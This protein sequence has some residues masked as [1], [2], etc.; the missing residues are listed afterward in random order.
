MNN[1]KPVFF[2]SLIAM[3]SRLNLNPADVLLLF[4]QESGLNSRSLT[5]K[6]VGLNQ[7][8]GDY[9]KKYFSG[10]REQYAAL[11]PEKQLES[12]EAFFKDLIGGRNITSAAQLYCGNFLPVSLNFPGVISKDRSTVLALRSDKPGSDKTYVP[13]GTLTYAAAY[14]G[15]KGLDYDHDGSIT[16]GDIEDFLKAKT[17]DSNYQWALQELSK[18]SGS[19]HQSTLEEDSKIESTSE[20]EVEEEGEIDPEGAIIGFIDMIVD[21]MNNLM[22]SMNLTSFAALDEE[23]NFIIKLSSSKL[24]DNLEVA[25]IL[26]AAYEDLL[27]AKCKTYTNG[28]FVEISCKARG[29]HKKCFAAIDQFSNELL[30]EFKNETKIDNINLNIFANK[31]PSYKELDIKTAETNYRKFQLK[32]L[33][34]KNG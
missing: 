1:L 12:I 4:A 26:T 5:A 14:D 3:C 11:A 20:N 32:I 21:G 16:Y 30:N 31:E 2:K 7:F 33:G 8:Y 18:V 34:I 15:N 13:N 29:E 24:E 23:N 19:E 6:T 10:T 17:S 9:Y 22:S 28:T 25:R 27:E